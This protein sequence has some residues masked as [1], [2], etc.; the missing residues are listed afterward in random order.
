MQLDSRK[1]QSSLTA[2]G[3]RPAQTHHTFYVFHTSAGKKTPVRT[4]TSHGAPTLND[5]LIGCMAKQCRLLKPEF[6][7]LVSCS[8]SGADYEAKLKAQGD[9]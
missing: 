3:F 1:V 6:V 9:I 8:L 4:K 2:K 5:H 7:D